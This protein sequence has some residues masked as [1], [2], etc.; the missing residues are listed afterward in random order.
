M[1]PAAEAARHQRLR[2]DRGRRPSPAATRRVAAGAAAP[3]RSAGR[4]RTRASTCWTRGCGRRPWACPASCT[5]AARAWRA[6]TWS[7]PGLTAERFVPDPFAGEPGARLY[8]TGDRGALAGRTASWSS[9]AALDHQVKVRGFRIELGEIEAALAR[10]P[11]GARGGGGGARGR[12][13]A[14]GGWWRTWCGGAAAAEREALRAHLRRRCRSYMVPAA[15]VCAG[16]AAADAERQGGP[17]ARCRRPEALRCGVREY[18]APRT[19]SWRRCWRGSGRRCWARSG[20]GCAD[21]FFELGGH[22]LLATRVVSR[23]RA[24]VRRGAAA[25]R[26][27]RGA[28]RWR[29]LAARGSRSTAARRGAAGAADRIGAGGARRRRCRCRSRSSGSGSSTSWSRA[30]P[31]TTSPRRVRLRGRAG[32]GGA[33]ADAATR[34]SAARG[35]AHHLRRAV[36]RR[37]GAGDRAGRRRSRLPLEDLSGAGRGGA[38]GGGRAAARGEEAQR[39]FDLDAG[40]LLRAR[41][42]AARTRTSTCCCLTMHHIVSR[43]V[44][45][46]ACSSASWRRSTPR[47]AQGRAVAA[48][49][50]AGAVRRLR[51]LAARAGWR[52]RCWSAQLGLLARALAGRA[53]AAGAARP[54]GR[55]RRC[56]RFRGAT[57]SVDAAAAS[58]PSALQALSRERGRDA[59]HD[60]AGRLPGAAVPLHRAGGRRRRHPDRRPRRG[61]RSRG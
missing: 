56:R 48:A 50:A 57:R 12:R 23:V 55:A 29:E 39:P 52:A 17:Q 49:G 36:G 3:C 1:P 5:S 4:W 46:W 47:S 45:A 2:P 41:A 61:P 54:T 51:G 34:S 22:S 18:V 10:A 11:G 42:A 8:R 38:R 16:G 58:W 7:A 6:A 15:F 30:A 31:P 35:A 24:G 27:L 9:W 21:N 19:P 32:R 26:A 59:V 40:P 33:G 53:G 44:V 14:S 28:R 13:R 25:A 37:A 20:W 60:A 43:R